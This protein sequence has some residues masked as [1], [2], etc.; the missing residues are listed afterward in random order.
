[1]LLIRALGTNFNEI[2][3][4]IHPFSLS[5]M[6]LKMS[7]AKWR[8][9][10]LGLNELRHHTHAHTNTE[11]IPMKLAMFSTVSLFSILCSTSVDLM[12]LK[13]PTLALASLL[14]KYL[15]LFSELS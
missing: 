10:G 3:G 12:K 14:S 9:F 2:L 13:T 15:F 8:L 5:K 4:E 11:M 7:S 1:M 6:H